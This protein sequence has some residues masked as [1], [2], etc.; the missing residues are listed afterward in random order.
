MVWCST[1][2]AGR[3][4]SKTSRTARALHRSGSAQ[5][6]SKMRLRCVQNV[7]DEKKAESGKGSLPVLSIKSMVSIKSIVRGP[8]W[9]QCMGSMGSMGIM[10]SMR[11]EK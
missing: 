4:G 9:G 7:L 2:R 8:E 5:G 6:V 3:D 11:N 10:G 1:V